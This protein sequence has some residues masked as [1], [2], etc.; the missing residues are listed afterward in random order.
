MALGYLSGEIQVIAFEHFEISH[1]L[2]PDLK[3]PLRWMFRTS[4][5]VYVESS[6]D[7]LHVHRIFVDLQTGESAE[8]ESVPLQSPVTPQPGAPSPNPFYLELEDGNLTIF[9]LNGTVS[10]QIDNANGISAAFIFRQG[11]DYFL[12]FAD[13]PGEVSIW[14]LWLE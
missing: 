13:T 7:S 12:A 2:R 8:A 1:E 4:D 10:R 5:G 11:A 6:L 14:L 3:Y 9:A